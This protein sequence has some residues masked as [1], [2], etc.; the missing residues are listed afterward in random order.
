ML[1]GIAYLHILQDKYLYGIK[2]PEKQEYLAIAAYNGGVGRVIRR[3]LKRHNVREMPPLEVYRTLMNEMP[4]ETKDYLAKVSSR[5][6]NYLAW[7]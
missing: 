7:Q 2:D 4:D 6:K 5:K 3:M 1:L